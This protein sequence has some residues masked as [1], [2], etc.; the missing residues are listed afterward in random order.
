MRLENQPSG[1]TYYSQNSCMLKSGNKLL[2]RNPLPKHWC[3]E[4]PHKKRFIKALEQGSKARVD[5]VCP[6][7]LT[8]KDS[9]HEPEKIGPEILDI[10]TSSPN[11][12]VKMLSINYFNEGKMSPGIFLS[13]LQE[14]Y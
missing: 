7:L 13:S 8:S 5:C 4:H 11:T 14:G 2:H 3:C 10:S 6:L 12:D 9:A 1:M